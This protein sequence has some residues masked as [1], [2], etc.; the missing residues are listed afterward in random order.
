MS[1][2]TTDLLKAHRH[3]LAEYHSS[4][5]LPAFY[6]HDPEL[7]DEYNR[8]YRRGERETMEER[9]TALKHIAVRLALK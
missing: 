1:D 7:Q 6:A 9:R 3:G 5:P 4:F 8:G 2:R